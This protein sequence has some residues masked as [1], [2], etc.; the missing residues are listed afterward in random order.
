MAFLNEYPSTA[1][2]NATERDRNK[3]SGVGNAVGWLFIT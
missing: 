2:G 1:G 3:K